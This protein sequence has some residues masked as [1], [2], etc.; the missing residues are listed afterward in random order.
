VEPGISRTTVPA[1]QEGAAGFHKGR[2]TKGT[3][4]ESDTRRM[5]GDFHV[6][7]SAARGR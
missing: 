1:S 2:N 4:H 7:H 6:R 5:G 3:R